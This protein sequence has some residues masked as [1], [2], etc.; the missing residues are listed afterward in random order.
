M[1]EEPNMT[2]SEAIAQRRSIRRYLDQ[3]V[4][5]EKLRQILEAGRLSPSAS[6]QQNWK[7]I[8]VRDA[9]LR[10]RLA[11]ASLGQSFVGEAPVILAACGT[12]PEGVMACGQHRY[13][14]DLSIATAYMVLQAWE[15]GLG[16][17]W[18]GRFDEFQ[19]KTILKIPSAVRV[20]AMVTIGYPD[21]Q[22]GPRP[23]KPLS[24]VTC[25]DQYTP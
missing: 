19:V 5:D 20:V 12:D 21:E 6:N 18:L 8:T 23:R 9:G 14:V 2:V 15:L 1:E 11:K 7:F 13:T 10:A 22:P 17:C 3:P 24:E 16:T 4:E 25:Y